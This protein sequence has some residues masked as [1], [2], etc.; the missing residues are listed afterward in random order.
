MKR[1]I[2]VFV[3]I[4]VMSCLIFL[5]RTYLFADKYQP[6]SYSSGAECAQGYYCIYFGPGKSFCAKEDNESPV[7]RFPMELDHPTICTQGPKTNKGR[8]HS[9]VNTG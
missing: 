4:G 2:W 7:I 5:F 8:T 3:I 9:Y 6:C 1:K